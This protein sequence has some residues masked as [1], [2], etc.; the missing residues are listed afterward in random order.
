MVH[1]HSD[2][3]ST[4]YCAD[5]DISGVETWLLEVE[6]QEV[7]GIDGIPGNFLCSIMTRCE[8]LS[9]PSRL[10]SG[11]GTTSSTK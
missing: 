5:F 9:R 1:K 8:P 2:P 7:C 10:N 11:S 6:C 4:S 3:V